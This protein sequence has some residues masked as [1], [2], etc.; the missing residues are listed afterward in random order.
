MEWCRGALDFEQMMLNT[1]LKYAHNKCEPVKP[2]R[3]IARLQKYY[4]TTNDL[5][6]YMTQKFDVGKHT[7]SKIDPYTTAEEMRLNKYG[8]KKTEF[9]TGQQISGVFSQE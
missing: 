3:R 8:F 1:N 9:L 4:M 7:G 2:E 6:D 5:G